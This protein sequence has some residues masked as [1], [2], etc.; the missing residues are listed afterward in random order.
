VEASQSDLAII[1]NVARTAAK[2][3]FANLFPR[4][5]QI[6]PGRIFVVKASALRATL[7]E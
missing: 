1:A 3:P 5:S 6:G 7:A 4:V 2:A